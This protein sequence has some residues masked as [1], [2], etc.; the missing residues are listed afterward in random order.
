MLPHLFE[1]FF[2]V[3]G[4]EVQTGSSVGLGLGLYIARRIVER[5]GGR[6]TVQSAPGSGSVFSVALPLVPEAVGRIE[7]H[8]SLEE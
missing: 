5:H 2:R 7:S 3:P 4:V 1:R 6:I 8:T